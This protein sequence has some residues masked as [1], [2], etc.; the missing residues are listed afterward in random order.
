MATAVAHVTRREEDDR[1]WPI[2]TG[3]FDALTFNCYGTLID[4][5]WHP[6]SLRP[7]V[8]RRGADH[9][10]TNCSGFAGFEA[11][12]GLSR[13]PAIATSGWLHRP[14]MVTGFEPEDAEVAAFAVQ[15]RLAGLRSGA[16]SRSP[17]APAS[18]SSRTVTTTCSSARAAGWEST[19]RSW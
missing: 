5:G 2:S 9:R 3:R 15:V 1:R 8:A 18:A 7:V 16:A 6:P 10:T 11:V 12:A 14:V 19:S 13:T 4:R 17:R